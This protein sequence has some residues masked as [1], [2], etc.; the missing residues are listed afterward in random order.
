MTGTNRSTNTGSAA[1]PTTPR[2]ADYAELGRRLAAAYAI[3]I[4][5]ARRAKDNALEQS[6][7]GEPDAPEA[8]ESQHEAES[9]SGPAEGQMQGTD[10]SGSHDHPQRPATGGP[11]NSAG[12]APCQLI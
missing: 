12:D 6:P 9:T 10:D 2:T 3:L 5:V 4:N 1:E 8:G 11:N 7:A